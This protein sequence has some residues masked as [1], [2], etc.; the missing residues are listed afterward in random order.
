MET[1]SLDVSEARKTFIRNPTELSFAW[2]IH[3]TSLF[4][5]SASDYVEAFHLAAWQFLRFHVWQ[6]QFASDVPEKG[7]RVTDEDER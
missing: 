5:I 7:L 2:R 3:S 1:S 4:F 6:I